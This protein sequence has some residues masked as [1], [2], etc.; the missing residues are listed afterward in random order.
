VLEKLTEQAHGQ[1][2]RLSWPGNQPLVGSSGGARLVVMTL[3]TLQP[4]RAMRSMRKLFANPDDTH[5][6]FEI[7]DALQGPALGRMYRRLRRSEQGKRL[8]DEQPDLVPILSDRERLRQMPEGSL[9][10]AYLAFVESEGI[11]AAGLVD[12][13]ERAR[14]EHES[15]EIAWLRNWLR[16]THDL[17]HTV[18]G[19]RGDL[20]GEAAIL[21]F[22]HYQTGNWGVGMIAS[23]AWYKLGRV[24]APELDARRI[25]RDGRRRAKQMR[26][27]VD[28]P[29]HEWLERPL[30]EVRRELRVPD[31]APYR[32]VRSHEVDVALAA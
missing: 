29:W 19:Y 5:Y 31:L 27:F 11:S 14:R 16:D 15:A 32:P 6:V 23:M 7:I 9:G 3:R 13:S 8:L 10:R 2:F 1:G 18:L 24:T 22:S 26:W 25:V 12:A 30:A 21:A 4:F 20:I 28:V 17:W